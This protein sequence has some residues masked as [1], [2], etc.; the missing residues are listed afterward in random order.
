MPDLRV[1]LIRRLCEIPEAE[2]PRI[3]SLFDHI[4]RSDSEEKAVY[5][6]QA[7]THLPDDREA[8]P[9]APIHRISEIGTYMV[10]AATVAKEHFFRGDER[11]SL[12]CDELLRSAKR[13]D[14]VLEAWAVFSNHYHWVG[15]VSTPP[16]RIGDMISH[17]HSTTA[18]EV[19]RLDGMPGRQVW[20]NFWDSQLTFE[21]SYLARLHY[22][23][24][25]AVKHGLVA[26]AADYRWCSAGWFERTATPAQIK[27]IY[28]FK[29]DKVK[30]EDS[31]DPV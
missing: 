5:F 9:H 27:T 4:D 8:W 21:T 25:N 1:E 10:T 3:A 24:H 31:F 11:L 12:L 20:F 13:F 17:L 2:L 6:P 23:H 28:S 26:N 22:V 16:N 15:H 7:T 19:N 30:V 29:C 14:V 18:T